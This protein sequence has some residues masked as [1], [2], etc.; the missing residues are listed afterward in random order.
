MVWAF[1]L[2]VVLAVVFGVL[3]YLPVHFVRANKIIRIEAWRAQRKK[4]Q[5]D[6][7]Q[8][9]AAREEQQKK[10]KAWSLEDDDDDDEEEEEEEEVQVKEEEQVWLILNQMFWSFC[11]IFIAYHSV[12]LL[13]KALLWFRTF[14]KLSCLVVIYLLLGNFLVCVLAWLLRICMLDYFSLL[15]GWSFISGCPSHTCIN[16]LFIIVIYIKGKWKITCIS[17]FPIQEAEDEPKTKKI[18]GNWWHFSTVR[19]S[20]PFLLRLASSEQPKFLAFSQKKRSKRC[21]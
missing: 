17:L 12:I 8:T 11:N 9:E 10:K 15:A 16:I 7:E 20:P 4:E 2:H 13:T 14:H 5:E 3:W 18:N 21:R 19:P 1:L 6:K